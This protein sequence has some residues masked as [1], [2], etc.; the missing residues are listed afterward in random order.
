MARG[1][2]QLN[3]TLPVRVKEWVMGKVEDKC[4]YLPDLIDKTRKSRIEA[5]RRLLKMN[6]LSMHACIYYA[7][8]TTLLSLS[9]LFFSY[10]GLPFL[11]I[12]SAIVV[13]ICTVYVSAQNYAARAEQ[14]KGCYLALQELHLSLDNASLPG[15]C[16]IDSAGQKYIDIVRQTENHHI[17]DYQIAMSDINDFHQIL[18]W[19]AIRFAVYAIPVLIAIAFS[20][21][22]WPV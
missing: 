7:C 3:W 18:Y 20:L 2:V 13:T 21:V 12:S 10:P 1:I 4:Q 22:V 17:R 11:S 15:K 6:T 9:A 19:L 14:M 5:E 8:I 16:D